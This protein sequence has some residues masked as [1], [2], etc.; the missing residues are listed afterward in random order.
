MH[1]FDLGCCGIHEDPLAT[2]VRLVVY[3]EDQN[4][5]DDMLRALRSYLS[6][7]GLW[8]DIHITDVPFQDWTTSW[9]SHFRPV[10]PTPRLAICPP[11]DRPAVIEGGFVIVIDPKMAFGTG[12][13]ET[14]RLA[15]MGL[16]QQVK[17]GHRV[18]DVGT[19]SGILSIAAAK[20]GAALVIG[21]DTDVLAIENA[22]EN[23]KQNEVADIVEVHVG[24]VDGISGTFDVVV[25]NIISRILIV[26]L[27]ELIAR[28]TPL[29]CAI[30]GG[31]LI[32]EKEAFISAVEQ[33]GLVVGQVMEDGEWVCVIVT[34]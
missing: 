16:E 13:H 25:A 33:T 10:F 2:G 23:L 28:M 30:L 6:E 19:G 24:S 31:I 18:L 7:M 22:R 14:T 1:V 8:S 34:R 21:V 17:T 4:N 29:G 11:W 5:R 27:P 26:L 15:L 3:F 12:H 20:L 32:K 9:R